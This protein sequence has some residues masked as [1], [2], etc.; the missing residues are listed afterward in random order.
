MYEILF[1][2]LS[3]RSKS[4]TPALFRTYGF[5]EGGESL[6]NSSLLQDGTRPKI[7]Y[8]GRS[9]RCPRTVGFV[10][11]SSHLW[12][13]CHTSLGPH[14]RH[15]LIFRPDYYEYWSLEEKRNEW[16]ICDATDGYTITFIARSCDMARTLQ[17]WVSP[18]L[19]D[20]RAVTRC[21]HT[22]LW[23]KALG[24]AERA[25]RESDMRVWQPLI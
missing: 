19:A 7:R 21:W 9:R 1:I 25:S 2:I 22:E 24:C 10:T 13:V 3:T 6:T 20:T 18:S 8:H 16:N 15:S 12:P 4:Y 17:G 11:S 5:V 23:R 14:F